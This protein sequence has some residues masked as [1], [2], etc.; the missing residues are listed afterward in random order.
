MEAF[1]KTYS[2]PCRNKN[3]ISPIRDVEV[4]IFHN[5]QN[6]NI[7]IKLLA[8]IKHRFSQKLLFS[9]I[10]PGTLNLILHRLSLLV[11]LSVN[12]N[13]R[14]HIHDFGC[15]YMMNNEFWGIVY[16]TKFFFKVKIYY[17]R[18]VLLRYLYFENHQHS[19]L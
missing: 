2:L 12:G 9:N 7:G 13:K 5:F 14:Y 8:N 11:I 19:R 1:E 17:V 18:L 4:G 15:L 6:W 3:P 16:W 10:F